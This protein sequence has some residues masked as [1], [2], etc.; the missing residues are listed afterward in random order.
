[1]SYTLSRAGPILIPGQ[2]GLAVIQRKRFAPLAPRSFHARDRG[3][4]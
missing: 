2:P 1:M 4:L 3:A